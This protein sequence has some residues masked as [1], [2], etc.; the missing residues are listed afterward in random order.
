MEVGGW[1]GGFLGGW[2]GPSLTR[3]FLVGKSAQ[4]SPKPVLIL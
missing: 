1:V 2:M 4:N 3:N